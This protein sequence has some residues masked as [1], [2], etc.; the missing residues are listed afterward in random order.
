MPDPAIAAARIVF[1]GRYLDVIQAE[2]GGEFTHNR[3]C[4]GVVLVI[5]VTTACE[6]V[7]IEQY[8]IALNGFVIE[9]PAGL[10]GDD[11]DAADESFETAARRELLEESGFEADALEFLLRG[12]SSPGSSTE[13]VDFFLAPGARRVRDGGGVGHERI[14]VHCVKLSDALGW[15]D[16]RARRGVLV[17]PRV[18]LGVHCAMTKL[19]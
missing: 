6:I 14:T 8:R 17:D 5:P 16:E 11:E 4:R 13:V 15:L 3:R 9:Y 2:R 18:Y 12:P 19:R 7:F 10:V 1:R